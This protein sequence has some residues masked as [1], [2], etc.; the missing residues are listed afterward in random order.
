MGRGFTPC[1][2]VFWSVKWGGC[3]PRGG[4]VRELPRGESCTPVLP[5]PALRGAGPCSW[6]CHRVP[7]QT[8]LSSLH[9]GGTLSGPAPPLPESSRGCSPEA[10]Y[11]QEAARGWPRRFPRGPR[12][13]CPQPWVGAP[14]TGSGA[15]LLPSAWHWMYPGSSRHQPC[16]P[17]G[18]GALSDPLLT[19]K[20]S[21]DPA[22]ALAV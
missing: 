8:V 19:S 16:A 17:W 13:G 2:P 11:R 14:A 6:L 5:T 22:V 18:P 1:V 21:P 20:A 3:V 10:L 7:G 15:G 4:Q 12:P 9:M